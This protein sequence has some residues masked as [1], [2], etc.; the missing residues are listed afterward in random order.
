MMDQAQHFTGEYRFELV[1]GAGH[2]PQRE[3][4]AQVTQLILEWLR[5][6]ALRSDLGSKQ[7]PAD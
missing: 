7:G 2:F 6:E 4:P 3:K 5:P 1:A